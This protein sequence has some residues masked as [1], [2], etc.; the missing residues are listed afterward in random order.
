M[1]CF[2]YEATIEKYFMHRRKTTTAADIND[3]FN[4]SLSLPSNCNRAWYFAGPLDVH[5]VRE[6]IQ[7]A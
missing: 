4:T 5:K 7:E 2:K 3:W 6:L 1:L